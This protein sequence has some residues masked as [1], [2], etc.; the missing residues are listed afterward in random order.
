MLSVLTLQRDSEGRRGVSIADQC[1]MFP[2]HEGRVTQV[3]LWVMVI[4]CASPFDSCLGA[5]TENGTFRLSIL[6]GLVFAVDA[7]VF[8]RA[9]R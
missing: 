4:W 9:V 2:P 1:W 3:L 6:A 5:S 8:Q 7:Y